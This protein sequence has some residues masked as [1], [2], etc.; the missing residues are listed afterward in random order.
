MLPWRRRIYNTWF[1]AGSVLISYLV[2]DILN[3]GLPITVN[4]NEELGLNHMLRFFAILKDW[5][6]AEQAKQIIF[7]SLELY[8][9]FIESYS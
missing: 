5:E 8:V 6:F 3:I 7:I 9:L 2:L 4:I 1:V